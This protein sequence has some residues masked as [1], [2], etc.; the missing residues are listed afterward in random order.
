MPQYINLAAVCINTFLTTDTTKDIFPTKI[1]QYLACGKAVVATSL[2]G[3]RAVISGEHEGIAYADSLDEIGVEVISLLKSTERRRQL[4]QAGLNYVRQ[5]HSH[6]K[7]AN[8]LEAT[9]KE[10]IGT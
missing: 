4:E 6:D 9:L 8:Q 2:P 3:M 1:L 7:I 10:I 5:M